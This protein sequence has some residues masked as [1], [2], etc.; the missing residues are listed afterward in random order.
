[1]S[2]STTSYAAAIRQAL[3]D[4]MDEQPEVFVYG[5]DVSGEFGGA[6][7]ITEGLHKK[8]PERVINSPISE[9][10]IAGIGIGAALEGLRPVIEFQFADFSSIAFN[11][12][13]NHAAT[14][15][16]RTGKPC[17]L[18]ARMPVGGTAGG[19]PFHSQMPEAWYAHHP[20]LTVLAPSTV[21]DAYHQLR[22]ALNGSDPIIFCEHK[23]LYERL[24]D[25]NF[26][27]PILLFR[28]TAPCAAVQGS[29]CTIVAWSAMLH[30]ALQGAEIL[31][32]EHGIQC[33]VI[34]P[35][36]LR[37]LDIDSILQSVAETGRLVVLSED[38]PFAGIA[39]E[40]C[41]TVSERGFSWLD[42]PPKRISALDTPVPFHP[43]LWRTHRLTNSNSFKPCLKL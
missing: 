15:F 11:Q 6:F 21:H 8:Y 39:A 20:G 42:A 31:A 18:V 23:L 12:L 27:M 24:R 30:E 26:N 7:K 36:C 33:D 3:H 25:D 43:E 38:F 40:I 41:A 9:D 14:S 4:A 5:E 1:M 29:D 19:G 35:R 16:W 28:C 10:A 32:A 17:P 22:A 37:P 13:V 34:D 2:A